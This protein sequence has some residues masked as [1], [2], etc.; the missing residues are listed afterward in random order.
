M[1][2]SPPRA[3][4][5]GREDCFPQAR[6]KSSAL[7][8]HSEIA[9]KYF[10][11]KYSCSQA[12]LAAFGREYGLDEAMSLRV[13]AGFGSGMGGQGETC[14]AL[15]GAYMVIGLRYGGRPEQKEKTYALVR[16]VTENFKNRNK[17]AVLCRELLGC[18]ITGPSGIFWAKKAGLFQT[19]CRKAVR[20]AVAALEE[21]MLDQGEPPVF[22]HR[23]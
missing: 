7:M 20:D 5:P 4:W 19:V 6:E 22:L 10:Q 15:T 2:V 1:N 17:G 9:D 8:N 3:G 11:E 12:I 18:D 21:V 23:M 13:A 16:K 14:G